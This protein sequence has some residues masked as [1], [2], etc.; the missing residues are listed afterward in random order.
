MLAVRLPS[1][2]R[3]APWRG[4]GRRASVLWT[5]LAG[6]GQTVVALALNSATSL[7]AGAVLGSITGT[8]EDV[9]GLI[10]MVPA[11]IGLRGN[12]FA[13]LGSRL[14]TSI[15]TGTFRLSLRP[16]TVVGD[17]VVSS[18]LLTT[19]LA[20]VLAV[21]ADL[22][23]VAFGVS[24]DVRVADLA[25]VSIVGG[26]LASFVV[27]AAT[28]ALAGGAARYGWDLD[29]LVAPIVST[30]GDVLTLPALWLAALAVGHGA[31]TT[32]SG[33]LVAVVGAA[34]LVLGVRSRVARVARIMRESLPV[35]TAALLLST[36]AGLVLERGLATFSALPALLVLVPAFVSTA[37]ALGGVLSA[38]LATAFHLGTLDAGLV[39][40]SIAR[41]DIVVLLVLSVPVYV[42]NAA[43]AHIVARV[44][45]QASPGLGHLVFASV[46]GGA[47]AVTFVMAAAYYGALAAVRFGVD[48]DTYGIP[49]VTSSVDFAGVVAL[50]VTISALGI[51]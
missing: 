22:A 15:H 50:M 29:N 1:W 2:A 32:G 7:V 37:G 39:P 20:L 51:A 4:M 48:P 23:A 34:A 27:L 44:L 35:L 11:A 18:L 46:I 42:V 43:G 38:R 25:L 19:G 13:A 26:L 16:G 36:L 47:A 49:L 40:A 33:W 28:I 24:G 10:V 31:L 30:L 5:E 45:G 17:N 6:S 14:S 21:V 12:V 9:P 41:R 3:G 8:L